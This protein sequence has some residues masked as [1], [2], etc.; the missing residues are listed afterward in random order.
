M[1]SFHIRFM[2]QQGQN[3]IVSSIVVTGRYVLLDDDDDDDYDDDD[4][5]DDCFYIALSSALEQ[6]HRARI[7]DPTWVT[8]FL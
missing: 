6:T 1:Q 7:Y 3:I 4:D 5:D 2:A 8:R